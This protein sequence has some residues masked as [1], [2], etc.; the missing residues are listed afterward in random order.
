M[1]IT[2]IPKGFRQDAAGRLVPEATIKPIDLLRDE[3]AM[4]LVTEAKKVSAILKAL[5]ETALQE[6]AAF[7]ELS[8]IEYNVKMGGKKGNVSLTTFDGRYKIQ[9]ANHDCVTFDERLL[10]AKE[11]I[12][13]CLKEWVSV[14]GVPSGLIVLA[15]RA[16]RRNRNDE[17]SVSRVL[18]LRTHEIDDPRWKKAMDIIADSITVNNSV[19]YIR[20]YERIGESDQYKQISLDIAGV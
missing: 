9:R 20:V 12:D 18:D 14:H 7:I 11:L 19:T 16:F 5:R 1:K 4:R 17:I 13:E 2:E 8:A 6:I 10:A 15:N 3:T